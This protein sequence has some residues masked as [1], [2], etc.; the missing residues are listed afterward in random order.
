MKRIGILGGSFDPIHKGHLRLARAACN[1]L[2]LH[3]VIFLPARI[4]PH[5]DR[6]VASRHHRL[7]ML[8]LALQGNA[9]F[10]VSRYEITRP[11]TTFTRQS[12]RHFRARYKRS[13]IFFLIGS[14]SLKEMD[15]WSG[16]YRLLNEC[17]FVVGARPGFRIS[18][19]LRKHRTLI[20]MRSPMPR[21]SATVVRRK[22]EKGLPLNKVISRPVA[23]YIARHRL[24]QRCSGSYDA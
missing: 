11:R 23:R 13:R 14:D 4:P 10:T 19:K 9:H 22:I 18:K 5:K 17:V 20:C 16:G 6:L 8:A 15:T 7:A 24:Y 3:K 12:I 1:E 21:L 2:G